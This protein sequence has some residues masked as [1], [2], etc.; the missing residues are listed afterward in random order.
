MR[1]GSQENTKRG[2]NINIDEGLC[3]RGK[4]IARKREEGLF[5]IIYKRGSVEGVR[6]QPEKTRPGCSHQYIRGAVWW[7]QGC[8]HKNRKGV[9]ISRADVAG[10]SQEK[11][12]GGTH[13]NI[14]ERLCG[15]GKGAAEKSGEGVFIAIYQRGCVAGARAQPEEEERGY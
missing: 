1:C 2:I 3:D 13:I 15:R 4:G 6:A 5:T 10:R 14:Y 11:R 7:G 12:K 8:R 9:F